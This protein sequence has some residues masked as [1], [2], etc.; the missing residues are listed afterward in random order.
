M[1]EITDVIAKLIERTDQ[2]KVPWKPAADEQTFIA[3]IGDASVTVSKDTVLGA[4]MRVLDKSGREIYALGAIFRQL[5]GKESG[6]L[7]QLHEK[8]RRYALGVDR[9]LDELLAELERV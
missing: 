3:V 4:G 8:A 7:L 5:D 9:Q 1:A 6:D 2:G